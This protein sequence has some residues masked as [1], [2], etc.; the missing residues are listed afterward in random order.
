MGASKFSGPMRY[1]RRRPTLALVALALLALDVHAADRTVRG[2]Q[3]QVRDSTT[4]DPARRKIVG[5]AKQSLSN[6]MVVGDPRG[7]GAELKVF[8][9]GASSA[10]QAFVLPSSGWRA[11]SIGYKYR[12]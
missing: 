9:E 2:R 11:T 7:A 10:D 6:E 8:V 5:Q 12:D 1:A 4:H 3:R